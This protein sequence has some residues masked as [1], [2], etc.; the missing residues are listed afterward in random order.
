MSPP[1][2][3]SLFVIA[4]AG[5]GLFL[6]GTPVLAGSGNILFLVQD[7][8]GA[9]GLGQSFSS[10]QSGSINSSIGSLRHPATQDGEGN[11]ANVLILSNCPLVSNTCGHV[12]LSQ[13]DFANAIAVIPAL[14][15]TIGPYVAGNTASVTVNG[16]GSATLSQ[17]GFGNS[18]SLL[19][20]DAKINIQQT[21][22][23]NSASLNMATS[24]GSGPL[25]Q[26][27]IDQVGAD[28]QVH[29]DVLASAGKTV[30]FTQIGTG[31]AY[32]TVA[33]P[34]VVSTLHSIS[35]VKTNF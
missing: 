34:V 9:S 12:D 4:L 8:G 22:L 29:L 18:A 28:N 24:G 3:K 19:A 17:Q 33:N 6:Q 13:N 26:G 2:S 35:I 15:S 32:G 21:G 7:S 30:S 27:T 5:V 31:L 23:D 11:S 16:T 1:I 14:A 20:T 10:D 25:A